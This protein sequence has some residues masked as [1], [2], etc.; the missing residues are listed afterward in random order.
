[1][2][3][4][5][6]AAPLR[7]EARRRG[8]ERRRVR[9][10]LRRANP[11]MARV[12][13][14][15]AVRIRAE[16]RARESCAGR[17]RAEMR[18]RESCAGR[19]RAWCASGGSCAVRIRAVARPARAAPGESAPSC[20][21]RELRRANPHRRASGESCAGRIRAWRA[22]GRAAPGE[23]AHG[24]RPVRA[25]PCESAPSCVRR[26]LRRANPRRDA[27]PV[28]AA[29]GESAPWR[30]RRELCRANPR[31]GASGESCAGRIRAVARLTGIASASPVRVVQPTRGG[32][33]AARAAT[34]KWCGRMANGFS[35]DADFEGLLE[36]NQGIC[37]PQM[38]E[39]T[40]PDEHLNCAAPPRS[41]PSPP[42]LTPPRTA[43]GEPR[44][45]R[46]R[47]GKS[48]APHAS[49]I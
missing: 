28:R 33:R 2:R 45:M 40:T 20:V 19:I 24:A 34:R 22:S 48:S 46:A 42:L 13:Q 18:A 44:S 6:R 21:R 39:K 14:N 25:A 23:S 41:S 5:V 11:R 15:R 26:E 37:M 12:R 47:R 43:P 8:I 17:I 10:E 38:A 30:V 16:M 1:M 35:S 49:T 32:P 36:A 7:C 29:P 9:R 4:I 27:R 3:G 31:R